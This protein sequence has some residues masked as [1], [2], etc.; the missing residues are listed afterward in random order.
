MKRLQQRFFEHFIFVSTQFY[1]SLS[2]ILT[3]DNCPLIFN[4]TQTDTDR[5]NQGDECDLDDDNDGMEYFM[6]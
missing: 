1:P 3:S 2:G 4:P 5:D 6:Q